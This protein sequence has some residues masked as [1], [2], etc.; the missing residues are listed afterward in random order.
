MCVPC[1]CMFL[2][3]SLHLSGPESQ[4]AEETFYEYLIDNNILNS[5]LLY[6]CGEKYGTSHPQVQTQSET[7]RRALSDRKL[8]GWL[9]YMAL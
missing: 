7:F 5:I 6:T 8:K 9:Y 4:G 3:A 2:C 1:H